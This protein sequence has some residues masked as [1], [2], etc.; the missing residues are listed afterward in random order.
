MSL[1]MHSIVDRQGP[2]YS[3]VM[4]NAS[5]FD[6]D[7][8]IFDAQTDTVGDLCLDL[9]DKAEIATEDMTACY[10]VWL[11]GDIDRLVTGWNTLKTDPSDDVT[12]KQFFLAAH[13]L[14]GT[15]GGFGKPTIARLC[16]S[17]C[18]LLKRGEIQDDL[19]LINLH[20]DACKASM[21]QQTGAPEIADAVCRALELQVARRAA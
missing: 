20:V 5:A 4:Q 1:S 7:S 15:A 19:A 11:R 3:E 10:E 9:S 2:R 14:K 8:F 6:D 18:I 16:R 21:V 13:N 17:L 12:A